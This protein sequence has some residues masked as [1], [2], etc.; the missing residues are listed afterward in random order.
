MRGFPWLMT[1]PPP[2]PP[3]LARADLVPAFQFNPHA[4]SGRTLVGFQCPKCSKLF[5]AGDILRIVSDH[6]VMHLACSEAA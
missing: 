4:P 6:Y 3:K 5:K 2:A 1:D